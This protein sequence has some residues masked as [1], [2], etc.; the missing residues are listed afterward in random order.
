MLE[1]FKN[2]SKSRK[3]DLAVIVMGMILVF[4]AKLLR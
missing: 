2:L 1:W 3:Q 4:L